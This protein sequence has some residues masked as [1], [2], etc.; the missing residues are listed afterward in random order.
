MRLNLSK[1]GNTLTKD[2]YTTEDVKQVKELLYKEQQGKC[3]LSGI[4][5]NIKDCHT[6][7][8]H[9]S[10]QLV[11][12][13]LYKQA[14]MALGKLEGLWTRY[15]AYWYPGTLPEF[16]K[17]SAAYLERSNATPDRRFRH[18]GWIKFCKTQ[19]NKL[20]SKKMDEVLVELGS[21][22][23]RN[24]AERKSKFAKIVLDRSLGYATIKACI[25]KRKEST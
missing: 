10:E 21:T 16:L 4:A 18:P 25:D 5:V 7:H 3:A 23:G 24:L 2:L 9:N 17:A 19:F 13:A 1:K 11:R 14:N 8:N 15:L 22:P 6:D 20:S 12:G